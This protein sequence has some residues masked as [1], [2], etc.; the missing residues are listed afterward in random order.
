MSK[1]YYDLEQRSEEWHLLRVCKVGGSTSSQLHT[2]SDTLLEQMLAEKAEPYYHEDSF[3]SDAMQRGV[4]LEPY[5]VEAVSDYTG[6]KFNQ[7][8]WI[9]SSECD[10]LGISPDAISEDETEIVEIKCPSA[11]VHISYIRGGIVPLD[12]VDQVVH[13]FAVHPKLKKVHF[14][15]FRPECIKPLFVVT[16]ERSTELNVGTKAR[17]VMSTVEDYAKTKI[18]LAKALESQLNVEYD[19]LTF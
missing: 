15:S 10:L 17:P 2:K 6:I 1:I 8:G 19:K 18:E 14:A 4:D 16:V 13:A 12:H 5:A 11:R 3:V 7:C 9:Q